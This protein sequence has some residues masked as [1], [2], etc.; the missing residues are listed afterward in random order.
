MDRILQGLG[1]GPG[2]RAGPWARGPARPSPDLHGPPAAGR[3]SLRPAR[4]GVLHRRLPPSSRGVVPRLLLPDAARRGEP[5]R[6]LPALRAGPDRPDLL[7][8]RPQH[9]EA[10]SSCRLPRRS[11]WR[12]RWPSGSTASRGSRWRSVWAVLYFLPF[13]VSLV[14]ASL[15]WQWLYEPVYGFLNHLL[16]LVGHRAAQ[17]AVEPRRG[18]AVPG[19]GQRLGAPRLRHHDLPGGAAGHPGRVLRGGRHR[20]RRPLAEL[21]GGDAAPAEPAARHGVDPGA[22]LQLQGLRPGVRDDPGRAGEREPDRDHAAL[23]HRLQ[24]LP[25]R[26][27]LGDGRVRLR[28]PSPGHA[29][30]VAA[31]PAGGRA[32]E[33][34]TAGAGSRRRWSPPAPSPCSSRSSGW[35]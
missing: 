6:R 33:E 13:A 12:W 14:A 9:G 31:V 24:V 17:V 26:G 1:A 35:R 27:R 28:V 8:G 11:S 7:A 16:G 29:R 2:G 20:R 5:V 10:C 4:P 3:I 18:A 30:P 25:A 32:I 34:P 23:R 19:P 22:D 15:V 21:P